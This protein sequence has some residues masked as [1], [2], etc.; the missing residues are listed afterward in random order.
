MMGAFRGTGAGSTAAHRDLAER[1]SLPLDTMT[2]GVRLTIIVLIFALA[3]AGPV[4]TGATGRSQHQWAD[5]PAI[6]PDQPIVLELRDPGARR[7]RGR[8]VSADGHSVTL[9][10]RSWV[11]R[12]PA[13]DVR[14]VLIERETETPRTATW[15]GLAAGALTMG[16]VTVGE[17]GF[18]TSGVLGAMALGAALGVLVARAA[19]RA[20][21]PE[22]IY[23]A[24]PP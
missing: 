8:F 7:V 9:R 11:R 2:S 16:A 19:G 18:T 1:D 20:P 21:E 17:A 13:H 22:I 14:R 4:A 23:E 6:A 3:S 24:P 12:F 10:G 5:V 15:I